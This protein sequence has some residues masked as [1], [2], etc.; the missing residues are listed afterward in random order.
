MILDLTNTNPLKL[1]LQRTYFQVPYTM[2]RKFEREFGKQKSRSII[3]I[4]FSLKDIRKMAITGPPNEFQEIYRILQ[5]YVFFEKKMREFCFAFAHF[6]K[7]KWIEEKYQGWRIYD[8]KKEFRRQKCPIFVSNSLFPQNVIIDVQSFTCFQQDKFLYK[9]CDNKNGNIC[10]TY[11]QTLIAP[12]GAKEKEIQRVANFRSMSRIP[13]MSYYHHTNNLIKGT[14][15]RCSQPSQGLQH[16]SETDQLY[17]RL[18]AEPKK[19]MS[20]VKR[21]EA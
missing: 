5:Q 19:T 4:K 7:Q 13:I 8:M 9:Y 2:I 21:E 12:I 1:G 15:W 3:K 14:L 18:L 16:Y 17:L 10:P 20:L 6:Q 11:G